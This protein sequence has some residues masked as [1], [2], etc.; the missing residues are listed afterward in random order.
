MR[1]DTFSP[2]MNQNCSKRRNELSD[3]NITPGDVTDYILLSSHE[4]KALKGTKYPLEN[5]CRT[6]KL[7]KFFRM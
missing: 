5:I 1:D 2:L 6:D 7:N 4:I 3:H